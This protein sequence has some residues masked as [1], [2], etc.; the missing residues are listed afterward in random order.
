MEGQGKF[1][2]SNMGKGRQCDRGC[3]CMRGYGIGLLGSSDCFQSEITISKVSASVS[4]F[5]YCLSVLSLLG[6]TVGS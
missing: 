5:P 2:P 1:L 3:N 6:C 4:K